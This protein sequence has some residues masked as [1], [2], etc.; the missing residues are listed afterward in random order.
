MSLP[1]IYTGLAAQFTPI[2]PRSYGYVPNSIDPPTL[3]FNLTD[4]SP[5]T[6]GR[7]WMTLE[8]D[9]FLLVSSADDRAGQLSLSQFISPTGDLSVW[10]T[11]GDNNDLDLTDGTRASMLR[12]RSLSIEE[13]AAYPYYGGV[14]EFRVTTPGV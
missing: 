7:G 2:I 8:F 11:F 4:A 10:T 6:M 13:L 3:F 14:L 12:Y 1:D 5:S 9:G